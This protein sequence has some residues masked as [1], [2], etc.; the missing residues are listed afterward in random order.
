MWRISLHFV[1]KGRYK[2]DI[3]IMTSNDILLVRSIPGLYHNDP[4]LVRLYR[5]YIGLVPCLYTISC[6]YHAYTIGTICLYHAFT[7]Y[8]L[9]HATFLRVC[10]HRNYYLHLHFGKIIHIPDPQPMRP[11]IRLPKHAIQCASTT[12]YSHTYSL[13]LLQSNT[14]PLL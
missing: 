9:L 11:M 3:S 6:L 8:V 4:S 5:A 1:F 14:A 13:S 7:I 2:P 10:P 12:T